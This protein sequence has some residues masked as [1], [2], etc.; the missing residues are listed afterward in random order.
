MHL[1][2]LC[3]SQNKQRLFLYTALTYRFLI[4]SRECLLHGTKWVFKSDRYSFILKG[5]INLLISRSVAIHVCFMICTVYGWVSY[6]FIYCCNWSG[7]LQLML[8]SFL[9]IFVMRVMNATFSTCNPVHAIRWSC[10]FLICRLGTIL[11]KSFSHIFVL[12]V[13]NATLSTC[14]PVHAIPECCA[15]LICRLGTILVCYSCGIYYRK[16]NTIWVWHRIFLLMS[17]LCCFLNK[18]K[19]LTFFSVCV[20]RQKTDISWPYQANVWLCSCACP[21]RVKKH[22]NPSSATKLLYN[23]LLIWGVQINICQLASHSSLI[24][25]PSSLKSIFLPEAISQLLL[26]VPISFWMIRTAW[27]PTEICEMHHQHLIL[28][29]AYYEVCIKIMMRKMVFD[30]YE[31]A[32]SKQIYWCG[33]CSCKG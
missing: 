14:N 20:T 15:F 18:G 1:C 21:K 3:G 24:K 25:W 10:A 8:K 13:T 28:P 30:A 2:V 29:V 6:Y 32:F 4:Q 33:C 27:H 16:Y 23:F 19:M 7:W 11:L 31:Y 22:S 9:H 12:R 17:H 26:L 5:L